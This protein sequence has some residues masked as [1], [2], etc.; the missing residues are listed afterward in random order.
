MTPKKGKTQTENQCSI[1]RFNELSTNPQTGKINEDSM[2][3][4]KSILQ[5][6]A[7]VLVQNARRPNLKNGDADFDFKV[8]GP[9]PYTYADIKS[10]INFKTLEARGRNTK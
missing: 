10:P 5:A 9:F 7:E 2:D 6:E 4:A 8:D 1:E 3:E